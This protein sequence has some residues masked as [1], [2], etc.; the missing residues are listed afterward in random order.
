MKGFPT[1]DI[2]HKFNDMT[3]QTLDLDKGFTSHSVY[4]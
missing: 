4:A 1:H 3:L 2:T